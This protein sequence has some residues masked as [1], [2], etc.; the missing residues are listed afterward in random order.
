MEGLR[1]DK[2][3]W[4]ARLCKSRSLAQHCVEEGWVRLNSQ[5]VGKASAIVRTGDE[6]IFRQGHAWRRVV[7]LGFGN[8][9]GP[10]AEAQGLY[11]D[12]AAPDPPPDDWA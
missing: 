12:L 7:V 10:A 3:L 6:L 1:I 9:R 5:P 4:F 11:R 2:W 8:R